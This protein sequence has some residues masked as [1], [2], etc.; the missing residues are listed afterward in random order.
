MPMPA[1]AAFGI[2]DRV[3]T[4]PDIHRDFETETQFQKFGFSP[5]H[6]SLLPRAARLQH[7]EIDHNF[8]QTSIREPVDAPKAPSLQDGR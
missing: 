7:I 1:V 6:G 3:L 5:S 2:P 4:V 8:S